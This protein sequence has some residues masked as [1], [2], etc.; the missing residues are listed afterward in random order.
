MN[1]VYLPRKNISSELI[2]RVLTLPTGYLRIQ[3]GYYR[4]QTGYLRFQPGYYRL[5]TGYYRLQTGTFSAASI[6]F[7]ILNWDS[8]FCLE[9]I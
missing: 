7:I 2:N 1:K 6:V 8:F 4:L 3:T 5:Q 9:D